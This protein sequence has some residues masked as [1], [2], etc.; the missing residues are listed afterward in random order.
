MSTDTPNRGMF[1]LPNWKPPGR[2]Q[3]FYPSIQWIQVSVFQKLCNLIPTYFLHFHQQILKSSAALW[4][5]R[6][7]SS[8]FQYLVPRSKSAVGSCERWVFSQTYIPAHIRNL[9]CG[10]KRLWTHGHT[11]FQSRWQRSGP[12]MGNQLLHGRTV[13][14]RLNK[15]SRRK[16][17]YIRL[18]YP[19]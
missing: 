3:H 13:F 10:R 14:N 9:R 18:L 11:D 8:C 16:V 1:S 5:P 4:S 2:K 6:F 15:G 19:L 7:T 17:W 12:R